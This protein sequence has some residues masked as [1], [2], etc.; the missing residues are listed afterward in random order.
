MSEEQTIEE[1]FHQLERID[2][3]LSK[4]EKSSA[5]MEKRLPEITAVVIT[6]QQALRLLWRLS[7][8]MRRMGLSEDMERAFQTLTKFARMAMYLYYALNLLETGTVYGVFA[9]VIGLANVF[10]LGMDQ[11]FGRPRY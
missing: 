8:L 9:G 10:M 6:T 2:A 4:M 11:F 3:L 1:I 5:A 7:S